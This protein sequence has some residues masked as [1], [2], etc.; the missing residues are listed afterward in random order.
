MR[1]KSKDKDL[2]KHI[3]R[4]YLERKF[5]EVCNEIWYYGDFD[6]FYDYCR[7]LQY[8]FKSEWVRSF[9][10]KGVVDVFFDEHYNA[11]LLNPNKGEPR[12]DNY[13]DF[14]LGEDK[15]SKSI[16]ELLV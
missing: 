14:I 16:K 2:V 9:Y 5:F 3:H 10:Y 4:L 7:H 13:L 12:K 15:K 8:K 6:F 1:L 11:N